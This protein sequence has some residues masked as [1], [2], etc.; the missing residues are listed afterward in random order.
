[1]GIWAPGHRCTASAVAVAL[2][3]AVAIAYAV[4]S[5]KYLHTPRI[6]GSGCIV[7]RVI[8]RYMPILYPGGVDHA[9]WLQNSQILRGW[10]SAE[11]RCSRA[12]GLKSSISMCAIEF[13][14]IIRHPMLSNPFTSTFNH[15]SYQFDASRI[16]R[17]SHL[18][19][20]SASIGV[21]SGE[22]C[23][24]FCCS[25]QS[26]SEN[27]DRSRLFRYL[28][29]RT[30]VI[31]G[32]SVEVRGSHCFAYRSDLASLSVE[33]GS[34]LTRIGMAAFLGCSIR[35]NVV[36]ASVTTI[37]G[38]A[39][40]K[41][42]ICHISIGEQNRYFHVSGW[43]LLDFSQTSLTACFGIEATVTIPSTIRVLCDSCFVGCKRLR[44]WIVSKVHNFIVFN[45]WHLGD[46]N[47]STQF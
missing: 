32:R 13:H 5:S 18:L 8:A 35:S 33:S 22:N 47:H 38:G 44:D 41:A 19:Q 36:L 29:L 1:M 27:V 24:S 45:D 15:M 20:D 4:R 26:T 14:P 2:A 31:L 17:P 39:F 40:A 3:A 16:G 7:R 21:C 28:G 12:P 37:C 23:E 30:A 46:G 9:E 6:S 25:G 34:K 42:R 10:L 11:M 43:C